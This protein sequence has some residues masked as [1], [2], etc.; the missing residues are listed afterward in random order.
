MHGTF[1]ICSVIALLSVVAPPVA[2][3][4]D[5]PR[6]DSDPLQANNELIEAGASDTETAPLPDRFDALPMSSP[7]FIDLIRRLLGPVASF[8]APTGNC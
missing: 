7:A 5:P 4:G 8:S 2:L 1:R 6:P 3:P